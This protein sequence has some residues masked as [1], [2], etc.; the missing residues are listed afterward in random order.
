MKTSQLIE[1]LTKAQSAYG[2][3]DVK[4]MDSETG[5]WHPIQSVIKLHPYTGP[6]GC[7]NRTQ[8]VNALALTTCKNNA[9]DLV[10]GM[11]NNR[12]DVTEK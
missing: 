11:A 7:M 3:H 2:D 4:L 12:I 8:A 6:H 5:D 10:L 9:E 1:L